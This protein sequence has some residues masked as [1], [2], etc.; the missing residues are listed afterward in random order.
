MSTN[1]G[2]PDYSRG[3]GHDSG[4]AQRAV[5]AATAGEQAAAGSS[6]SGGAVDEAAAAGGYGPAGYGPAGYGPAGYG[7]GGYGP[8]GYGP[9]GY[10]PG[11]AVSEAATAGGYGPGGYG[12]GWLRAWRSCTGR[13]R[14]QRRWRRWPCVWRSCVWRSWI[15]R[16]GIGRCWIRRPGYGYGAPGYGPAPPQVPGGTGGGWYGGPGSPGP[17]G[18]YGP[19]GPGGYSGFGD[20]PGDGQRRSRR[21]RRFLLAGA[22][23]GVA[24]ALAFTGLG[25]ANAMGP[26]VLTTSQIASKVDPGLVNIVTN[27]GYQNGQAAGTGMVLTST[28]EVLTNN[29][30]INGATS[31]K[32]TDI[33]NGRTYTAKVVGYDKTSD[34][35]VIQ[36]QNASGLQTVSLSSSAAKVGDKVVALGNAG[37]KGGTPSVATGKVTSLNQAITA[38]DEG[39]V[40]AERLTGMT[41]TNVPIQP[42]DSGGPLLNSAGE[43]VGM[44][45]AASTSIS[46]TGFQQQSGQTA[47]Q[48]FAIPIAKAT[49]IAGQIEAGQ[50]SST[51][52]LGSTAFLGVEVSANG[53]G[54]F[55]FGSGSS[56]SGATVEGTVSGSAAAQAGLAAG[57]QITSVGGHAVSSSPEIASV[58]QQYHPGQK[59]SISWTDQSGQSHTATVTLTTGPAA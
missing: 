39:A 53:T 22:S 37:G 2:E 16:P 29:H 11:G 20:G 32:A 23:V 34:V 15:R 14:C 56:S 55:G 9:G 10:G 33:G 43:V 26:T 57:D 17:G 54:G 46:T 5:P 49:A 58:L 3:S 51:V 45:T 42:G 36:L 59:I 1:F 50:A 27:L 48:A 44:N 18:W 24:A 4:D 47:T 41:Q 19:A 31:I 12:S 8:A 7:P 28:G 38:A 21:R 6:G 30:V 25:I 52:H 35:A 40:N 13:L